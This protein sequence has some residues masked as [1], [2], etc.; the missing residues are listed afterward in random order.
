MLRY[1]PGMTTAAPEPQAKKN[2]IIRDRVTLAQS[3]EAGERIGVDWPSAL[4]DVE[5]L[6]TG[7]MDE[8]EHRD[9][10]G[11]DLDTTAKIALAHL[12]K[13]PDYYKPKPAG[14]TIEAVKIQLPA[15]PPE[16]CACRLKQSPK[17]K[18]KKN[19][20][21]A[22]DRSTH[23]TV[24]QYAMITVG[25]GRSPASSA[26]NTVKKL[27]GFENMFLGSGVTTVNQKILEE[28]IWN[29]LI[30]S[31]LEGTKHCK[32]G[33]EHFALDGTVQL[34]NQTPK[35]RSELKS[36]IIE[37]LGKDPFPNDDFVSS[38]QNPKPLTMLQ[39][40]KKEYEAGRFPNARVR[41]ELGE[42]RLEDGDFHLL[43][44]PTFKTKGSAES[45]MRRQQ[46]KARK[47][48]E[49]QNPTREG[50]AAHKDY[51]E[52]QRAAEK[53]RK[54]ITRYVVVQHSDGPQGGFVVRGGD[55]REDGTVR[56]S[57]PYKDAQQLFVSKS[58]KLAQK[59]ADKLN[60]EYE[61]KN[62]PAQGTEVQSLLFDKS[63]WTVPS[64][65]AWAKDHGYK[66]GKADDSSPNVIRIRQ[67]DPDLEKIVGT[68]PFGKNTGI[69]AVVGLPKTKQN[70]ITK[71]TKK[72][73]AG[74]DLVAYF[75]KESLS[76]PGML[77]QEWRVKRVS[78]YDRDTLEAAWG[79]DWRRFS[80][81]AE[82]V[83][84]TRYIRD[85]VAQPWKPFQSASTFSQAVDY[86]DD[87]AIALSSVLVE[88]KRKREEYAAKQKM[89]AEEKRERQVRQEH[90]DASNKA[91]G[92]LSKSPR[93][94]AL[95]DQWNAF[96]NE[97]AMDPDY[98]TRM[99]SN[100]GFM[101]KYNAV[102][103]AERAPS[104][105]KAIREFFAYVKKE[106][107]NPIY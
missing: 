7:I 3:R 89:E 32:E 100:A 14:A 4:F 66:S 27:S 55:A 13:D 8:L 93:G 45:H 53:A 54:E 103:E 16:N 59:R 90:R 38:K 47:A 73:P 40:A 51:V 63:L 95:T 83:L 43:A 96:M 2:P 12:S 46:E 58:Q 44:D 26:K 81:E 9:V 82:Y 106:K 77:R 15:E 78:D 17:P 18:P 19:P 105:G 30:N 71:K 36:R 10:T 37:R 33:M 91:F 39:Y 23:P 65:K 28:E 101:E 35:V 20:S 67:I 6:R 11:G 62:P 85:G 99:R 22:T 24:V 50:R 61:K 68:I 84:E 94:A 49:K 98:I 56:M 57:T 1:N 41:E 21:D 79:P 88:Q 69:Q 74:T 25:K 76:G 104:K 42:F 52:G 60:E 75:E 31:V 29:Q 64:A 107:L 72:N 48:W 5:D 86:V 102:M 70:P 34:Y 87:R 92:D 97:H 80:P